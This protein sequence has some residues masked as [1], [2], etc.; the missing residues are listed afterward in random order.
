MGLSGTTR[1]CICSP[2]E[3]WA[4]PSSICGWDS[5]HWKRATSTRPPSI[6]RAYMLEG[7]EILAEDDPKY[8]EFLKTRLKPPASG[9]W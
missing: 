7:A 1:C 8:F 9:Q 6:A 5:V 4:T 3:A 2:L